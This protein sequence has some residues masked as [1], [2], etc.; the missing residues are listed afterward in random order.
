MTMFNRS[1]D[2]MFYRQ[3][4][5]QSSSPGPI[6]EKIGHLY[7]TVDN[8]FSPDECDKIIQDFNRFPTERGTVGRQDNIL[9]DTRFR[10]C[11][12]TYAKKDTTNAWF[13][14]RIE[15]EILS[16]NRAIW[17]FD[18]TDFSQPPRLMTYHPGDHFGSPHTDH[19]P[20]KTC[21]R[22]LTSI[23]LLSDPSEYVGGDLHMAGCDISKNNKQGI[24]II[25]PAYLVHHVKTVTSG[26]RQSLV[27]R[28]IGPHFK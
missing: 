3:L 21:F 27:Y 19:G 16:A 22:K 24:L 28:A 14:D 10:D 17:N 2:H 8:L 13:L 6:N 20:G 18:I 1:N 4:M 26:L 25:F 11:N 7:H 5:E 15:N 12:V 23:L 9:V